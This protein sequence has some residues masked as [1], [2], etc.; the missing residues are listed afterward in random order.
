MMLLPWFYYPSMA[1]FVDDQKGFLNALKLRLPT[2]L[3]VKLFSDPLKALNAIKNNTVFPHY[4]Y[5]KPFLDD[6]QLTEFDS[7]NINKNIVSFEWDFY[8]LIYDLNRFNTQ[9]VVIVDQMMPEMDGISF[10]KLLK[11]FPIKKIMLTAN[12]DHSIAVNAFNEGIIDYFLIKDSPNLVTELLQRIE[13]MQNAYFVS[14]TELLFGGFLHNTSMFNDPSVV[15]FYKKIKMEYQASEYYLLDRWGSMVFLTQG[16]Q[17]LTLVV[18]PGKILDNFSQVA[19]D[20]DEL[21]ISH[22]LSTKEKLIFFPGEQD[23]IMPASEW[24]QFLH[25]AQKFEQQVDMFYSIVTNQMCQP[26]LLEKIKAQK[27]FN[28]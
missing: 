15:D 21:M 3:P 17:S 2:T 8:E 22:A 12:A 28:C 1:I 11:N 6:D 24:D 7:E 14:Q 18:R 20:Q 9:S 25:P 10:C 13:L 23:H 19:A 26:L 4:R 16:G 5:Q 27:D